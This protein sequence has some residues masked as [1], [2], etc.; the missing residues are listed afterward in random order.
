MFRV[1]NNVPEVYPNTSRDFQLLCSLYDLV[2]QSSRYSIDSM[3]YLSDC[4]TCDED[5]LP[6][7]AKKLGIFET[8]DKFDVHVVRMVLSAFPN[9]MKYKGSK[10][11]LDMT[12][13]V[14]SRALNTPV[15][16]ESSKN[17]DEVI[18]STYTITFINYLNNEELLRI[19]LRYLLPTGICVNITVT[20]SEIVHYTDLNYVNS[21]VVQEKEIDTNIIDRS[22][23]PKV[24]SASVINN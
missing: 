15:T 17:G 16:W 23:W 11:C 2:F 4:K 6:L 9:I 5:M 20:A 1:K 22:E 13:N 21:T 18:P 19:L 24:G 10:N 12:L 7:L 8:L 14:F 3:P